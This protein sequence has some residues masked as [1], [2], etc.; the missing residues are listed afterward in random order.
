MNPDAPI[1]LAVIGHP[2][3]HSRSPRIHTAFAQQLGL[4]VDYQA[5]LAPLDGF[6]ATVA[7]LRTRGWRGCNVTLPFKPEALTLATQAS[8]RAQL[9]GAANTLGFEGDTLWADN[10]DGIG[11]VY[12]LVAARFALSGKRVLLLGAGGACAG[13]LAPLIEAGAAEIRIHNR[14]PDKASALVERHLPLARRHGVNLNTLGQLDG[15][16]VYDGVINGTSAGLGGQALAL[17][18]GLVKPGGWA[19]DLV[20]G[21]AAEPFLSWARAQGAQTRDGLG[22]LV[23]QAAEAFALWTGQRPDPTP[24]LEALRAEANT[25]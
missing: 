10:T 22:M 8:P 16:A 14:S 9:A 2:I 13:A 15:G 12:D 6:A 20:Y 23:Q 7:E 4:S 24:V 3:A 25:A 18:S 5:V 1:R 11:L 17:P 21:P 19:L